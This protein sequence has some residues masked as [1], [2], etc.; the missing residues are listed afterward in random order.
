MYSSRTATLILSAVQT[1]ISRFGATHVTTVGHSLGAALS[2]LDAVYL[3]L[4]LPSSI[5]FKT[6]AYGLPRVSQS[7]CQNRVFWIDTVGTGRQPGVRRLCR[8]PRR[9]VHSYQQQR[10]PDTHRPR[11]LLGLQPSIWR[12]PYHRLER[13]GSLSRSVLIPTSF[14]KATTDVITGQDNT[15][16]LCIVGDVSNIFEGDESDHDGPYDGVTMGC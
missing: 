14:Q 3:P 2:L 13:L 8:H 6:V 10:G 4:H 15:S 5:T 7:S 11:T 16:S 12:D 1:A 9:V